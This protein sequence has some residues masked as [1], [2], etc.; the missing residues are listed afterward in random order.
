[1]DG[2]PV[3]IQNASTLPLDAVLSHLE[4]IALKLGRVIARVSVDGQAVDHFLHHPERTGFQ[5]LD[6]ETV[7][8][9]DLGD[10]VIASARRQIRVLSREVNEAAVLVL[11]NEWSVARSLWLNLLP[12]FK[13]PMLGLGF[14]KDLWGVSV[15]EITSGPGSFRE[16]WEVLDGIL[17][18]A[19]R[20]LRGQED[21]IGFSQLL[22]LRLGPWLERNLVFLDCIHAHRPV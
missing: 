8:T 14:L 22:E 18:D 20:M 9:G 21:I 16:H 2:A 11:I 6:V 19:E 7:T 4:T 12:A 17:S 1:M 10:Q 13:T 3:G 15:D 5:R